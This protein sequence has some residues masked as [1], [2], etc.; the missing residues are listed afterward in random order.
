MKTLLTNWREI[1]FFVIFGIC[2]A[3]ISGTIDYVA[4]LFGLGIWAPTL[5]TYCMGFARFTGANF[6]AVFLGLIC[7]PTLNRFGNQS[8]SDGWASFSVKEQ[9]IVYMTVLLIEGIIAGLC[10]SA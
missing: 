4:K 9:T 5:A 10:F 6:C 7:W 3:A 2:L 1:A 8:F